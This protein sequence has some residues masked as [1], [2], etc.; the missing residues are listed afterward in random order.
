MFGVS[1]AVMTAIKDAAAAYQRKDWD[2]LA[3]ALLPVLPALPDDGTGH[4]E[5]PTRT[6]F[7]QQLGVMEMPLPMKKAAARYLEQAS[8]GQLAMIAQNVHALSAAL[9]HERAD[10]SK[11]S[12]L[13]VL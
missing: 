3:S 6:A 1:Y 2:A 5:T 12:N 11:P 9:P 4:T 13:M 7:A 10:D 8:D